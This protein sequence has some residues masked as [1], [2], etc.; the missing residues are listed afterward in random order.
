MARFTLEQTVAIAAINQVINEWATELDVDNGLGRMD[1]IVTDDITY[2]LGGVAKQGLA[3][4]VQFYKDRSARL[5]ATAEGVPIHRH[6]LSNLR[7]SFTSATSADIGFSLIYFSTLGN[8]K[9]TDHADPAAFADVVM[10]VR[11]DADG[12]WRICF[13]D[14]GQSF[15]RVLG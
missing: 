9:G 12:E 7:V 10:K 13:F 3:E 5:G 2:M 15:R 6:A 11:A 8:S 14:S 1:Q 4:V